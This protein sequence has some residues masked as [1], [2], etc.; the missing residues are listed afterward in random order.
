MTD[1]T[2]GHRHY[3]LVVEVVLLLAIFVTFVIF[4]MRH[5]YE[6][7]PSVEAEVDSVEVLLH[8]ET[9]ALR[10]VVEA[11]SSREDEGEETGMTEGEGEIHW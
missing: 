8:F 11:A 1:E 3:L 10:L 7:S 5:H 4:V 9:L 2:E 6:M